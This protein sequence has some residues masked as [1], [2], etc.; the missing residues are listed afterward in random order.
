MADSACSARSG[1]RT[2]SN[3]RSSLDN[4]EHTDLSKKRKGSTLCLEVS[5][6]EK[7]KKKRL[8][9]GHRILSNMRNAWSA[10]V[11]SSDSK[12][13]FK[14]NPS[15][16]VTPYPQEVLKDVQRSSNRVLMK[17]A[18]GLIAPKKPDPSLEQRSQPCKRTFVLGGSFGCGVESYAFS[19][20]I[21][22]NAPVLSKALP[23]V[24]ADSSSKL[25]MRTQGYPLVVKAIASGVSA[26]WSHIEDLPSPELQESLTHLQ[27]LVEQHPKWK[28]HPHSN[29]LMD[30]A[31]KVAQCD[32]SDEKSLL[33]EL[34]QDS[35]VSERDK[36]DVL[37]H[38]IYMA[39]NNPELLLES[40]AAEKGD[41]AVLEAM[42]LD[43]SEQMRTVCGRLTDLHTEQSNT[44]LQDA[45]QSVSD[46][47]P[48]EVATALISS[49]GWVNTGLISSM[50][51]V[52]ATSESKI[53]EKPYE[54]S[55]SRGLHLILESPSIR[56]SIAKISAP[57]RPHQRGG[58]IVR[59]TLGLP[60]SADL[61]AVDARR[62]VV[63]ALLAHLRQ[64][65][66]S[67]VC[68]ASRLAIALLRNHVGQ[69]IEDFN[70]LIQ[71]GSLSRTFDGVTVDL[72]FLMA[73][74]E[75]ELNKKLTLDREAKLLVLGK[76]PIPLWEV[77]GFLSATRSVGIEDPESVLST[78]T[79]RLFES[80][81]GETDETIVV[82]VSE[83]LRTLS[84]LAP[85]TSCSEPKFSQASIAYHSQTVN[86][87]QKAWEG[88]IAGL[89]HQSLSA[90]VKDGIITAVQEAL[91]DIEN[92]PPA[93]SKKCLS[94]FIKRTRSE[95]AQR[96]QL[97]YD[98]T[99]SASDLPN[100]AHEGAGGFV[101]YDRGKKLPTAKW[102]RV[103]SPQSF[104]R[105]LSRAFESANA[106]LLEDAK[107]S[108][109]E[110]EA[111]KRYFGKLSNSPTFL[112]ST[113]N[114]YRVRYDLESTRLDQHSKVRYTPWLTRTGGDAVQTEQLYFSN[115]GSLVNYVFE[116]KSASDV[117]QGIVTAIKTSP[118]E[119][120]KAF[121]DDSRPSLGMRV[122]GVHAFSVVPGD[123]T[124]APIWK[125]GTD[126]AEWIRQ[127]VLESGREVARTQIPLSTRQSLIDYC[128]RKLVKPDESAAFEAA[129]EHIP[130]KIN[131]HTFSK[132]LKKMVTRHNGSIPGIGVSHPSFDSLLVRSLPKDLQN[133]LAAT[134]VIVG[135][136]NWSHGTED[137][138]LCCMV[139]P[140]TGNL[141][142]WECNNAGSHFQ[143]IGNSWLR[144]KKWE[145]FAVAQH[146]TPDHSSQLLASHLTHVE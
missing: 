49:L 102:Q 104:A 103:A 23:P 84:A 108:K 40:V 28:K 74:P 99:C 137:V 88:A 114:H 72:P 63:S 142:L 34:Y 17:D 134:R 113:L 75:H 16:T 91:D 135:D 139:N 110:S 18:G 45:S 69:S 130:S 132:Q 145:I 12:D 138:L 111:L 65:Q 144:E 30:L 92:T 57:K 7:S 98:P 86:T 70:E 128:K 19:E 2:L 93:L 53:D 46:R 5:K 90:G 39:D 58:V 95:L 6:T 129:C 81:A 78:V 121:L 127:H 29:K 67:G 101:L 10:V 89:G 83:V 125:Q 71:T 47:I 106:R 146:H 136:T 25:K 42:E 119:M 35:S 54:A 115:K 38:L 44:G 56:T 11:S 123:P 22:K 133:R 26:T 36:M 77:P 76:S 60:S 97:V 14:I 82:S 27:L 8:R 73:A 66:H 122:V 59:T 143:A 31:L 96:V 62:A 105:F 80:R 21:Q 41:V 64:D 50:E 15:I 87:L 79:D 9:F 120:Q 109:L 126:S 100:P 48:V 107:I 13:S 61:T 131:I 94:A 43:F 68:F 1:L 116:P 20:S 117:L 118:S 52:F 85:A 141:D 112:E 55:L 51:R 124:L 33:T 37:G 24:M 4:D 32:L 3:P 140:S